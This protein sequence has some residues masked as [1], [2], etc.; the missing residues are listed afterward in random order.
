MMASF[1]KMEETYRA[2]PKFGNSNQLRA[3]MEQTRE[4]IGELES[5]LTSLR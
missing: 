2:N 1:L 4:K 3:E 5:L